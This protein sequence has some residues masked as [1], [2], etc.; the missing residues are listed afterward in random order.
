MSAATRFPEPRVH[1][2]LPRI[3][4][5]RRQLHGIPEV[6][7][8]L[9]ETVARVAAELRALGLHP[10]PVGYGLCVDIGERGPR[11]AIRADLDALPIQER[12][13][14]AHASVHPGRMHA[15]GHD[16]H[17]ACLLGVAAL[18]AEA[19]DL[20]FRVRLIFQTGEESV[21][22]ARAMIAAGALEGVTAI[23]GGHVFNGPDGLRPGQAG[24]LH[25][26]LMGSSDRFRGAFVGS[27]GHGSAPHLCPDPVSALAEF[28]QALNSF[29]ARRLD[30]ARPAVISVCSVHGGSA[31][32]VIPARVEFMGTA[33]CVHADLRALLAERIGTLGAE[34]AR[35]HG[36]ELE[37]QWLEGYPPVVNDARA[38]ALAAEAAREVLGADQV[39]VLEQ[40]VLAG[41]DFA[42]YLEQ[43][44]GCFWFLN[45]GDPDR[46]LTQPNHSDRF[47]V[48][49]SRIWA[50]TAV[51]LA[52]AERLAGL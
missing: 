37:Y 32:N 38:S 12:T 11:V 36:L 26:P 8:E 6:G 17:T 48:D 42:H 40:P 23:I 33:R 24:F 20:P 39:V 31:F 44:P 47:D 5:W 34:V 13:G 25:G 35:M 50:M 16:V 1:A 29:R 4:E 52:A 21:F 7:L 22:G 43:V 2:I 45:T 41:E 10:R 18:L 9:P 27:G 51:H 15:C 49:E 46:G 28:I 30:P 3:I 19:A 14:L